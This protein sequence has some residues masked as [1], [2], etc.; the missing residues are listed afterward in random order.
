MLAATDDFRDL[1]RCPR[2]GQ[3]LLWQ[4][5]GLATSNGASS[6]Y[7]LVGGVPLLVDFDRSVIDRSA[8]SAVGVKSGV[9]RKRRSGL[10]QAL[11][12]LVSPAKRSTRDNVARFQ[13]L[14]H[15]QAA[16][17]LVLVVGG[18]TVGQGMAPLYEDS[19]AR[20]IAFDIYH[21]PDV[22]FIADA[23]TI[24]MADESIDAV[25]I[26]A[27]LEHV[28]QPAAVVA[29]I[30]RVLRPGGV[31]YAETPFLQH[32]HEG[33]YD[34]TRFTESGHRFLFRRFDCIDSG[35]SGGPGTQ[36]LWSID[37][38]FRSLFRSVSAGKVAKLAFFWLHHV[39]RFI[40]PTY[41]SDAA[42]G[43]YFLG[44]KSAGDMSPLEAVAFYRG[45][46]R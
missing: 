22:H 19:E 35:A 34:F 40:P 28:L 20:I 6:A 32:V 39:D 1:L 12:S 17:P 30:W 44:V 10:S 3:P 18:G 16:K 23:H 7:P 46:Q 2:T 31:V 42:S 33:A 9:K 4:E 21:T 5:D 43:V 8:A 36:L 25:V 45:A 29:E 11:K 37:Y 14:V 41:A 38:F 13:S 26:Q 24:P 15:Q 27:V